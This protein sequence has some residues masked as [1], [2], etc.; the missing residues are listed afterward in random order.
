[1]ALLGRMTKTVGA[2]FFVAALSVLVL[3][4]DLKTEAGVGY[5]KV[6]AIG[7]ALGAVVSILAAIQIRRA[8]PNVRVANLLLTIG[9][10]IGGSIAVS[11]GPVKESLF[12]QAKAQ[13]FMLLLNHALGYF[14]VGVTVDA[15][16]LAKAK[17][18]KTLRQ[19]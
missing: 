16:R 12:G 9:A 11:L 15:V 4:A 13:A 10:L 2:V 19:R 3:H 14:L 6:Y 1:M 17:R 7:A 8:G 5:L 18:R